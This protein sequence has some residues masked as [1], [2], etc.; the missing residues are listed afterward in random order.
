MTQAVQVPAAG[1]YTL[2]QAAS[3]ISFTTTHM[4]GL[5]KVHGTFALRDCRIEVAG[6][7]DAAVRATVDAASIDTGSSARDKMVRSATYLDAERYPEF[8]FSSTG[9]EQADGRWVLRGSLTVREVSRPVDVH[10]Q[11]VRVADA[12]LHAVGTAQVDR[13]EFGITAMKG[14][15]GRR[16]T[17]RLEIAADLR[18]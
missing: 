18:P 16:L 14:M 1:T 12:A 11:E 8:S 7:Q 6:P 15:T 2:D 17:L 3:T 13:Y 10:V 5:G 4:F 9:L